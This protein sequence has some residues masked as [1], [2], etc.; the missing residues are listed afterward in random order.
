LSSHFPYWNYNAWKNN[1]RILWSCRPCMHLA[2][3]IDVCL[4]SDVYSPLTSRPQIW[5]TRERGENVSAIRRSNV[6][7]FYAWVVKTSRC[8]LQPISLRA[9]LSSKGQVL[10]TYKFIMKNVLITFHL[11]WKIVLSICEW[12]SQGDGIHV[13]WYSFILVTLLVFFYFLLERT[14]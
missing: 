8:K 13:Q 7:N 10:R 3:M 2:A 11:Q 1:K 4:C 14:T 9:L 6:V 12:S 5:P